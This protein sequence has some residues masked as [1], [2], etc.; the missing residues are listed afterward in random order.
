[1]PNSFKGLAWL[2][3]ILNN[4]RNDLQLLTLG[5]NIFK[6]EMAVK[7][8]I[9]YKLKLSFDRPFGKITRAALN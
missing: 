7:F 4:F 5:V 1:M 6:L 8:E 2:E 9:S 3:I